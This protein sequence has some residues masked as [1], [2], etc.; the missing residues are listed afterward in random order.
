MLDLEPKDKDAKE[1]YEGDQQVC[2]YGPLDKDAPS[3]IIPPARPLCSLS[4]EG[5]GGGLGGLRGGGG[6]EGGGGGGGVLGGMQGGGGS[7]G[8]GGAQQLQEGDVRLLQ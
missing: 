3:V 4:G 6:A 2:G 5:G 1:E 8:G 7:Q